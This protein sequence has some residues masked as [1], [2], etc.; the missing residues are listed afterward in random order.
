M[1]AEIDVRHIK[2]FNL[3]SYFEENHDPQTVYVVEWHDTIK[4]P[5]GGWN[6]YKAMVGDVSKSIK[7]LQKKLDAL[8]GIKSPGPFIKRVEVLEQISDKDDVEEIKELENPKKKLRFSDKNQGDV[9]NEEEVEVLETPSE[10][11][12]PE[13]NT[14]SHVPTSKSKFEEGHSSKDD[15]K[16]KES[17]KKKILKHQCHPVVKTLKKKK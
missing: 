17:S 16:K 12:R 10:A 9:L 13:N 4:M 2:D 14:S 7:T 6:F 5:L 11:K 15:L 3:D 1:T 8:E